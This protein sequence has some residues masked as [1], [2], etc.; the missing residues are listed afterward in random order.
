MKT[1]I[2]FYL[3]A[4]ITVT[5]LTLLPSSNRIDEEFYPILDFYKEIG[6]VIPTSSIIIKFGQLDLPTAGVCNKKIHLLTNDI[7]RRE[8]VISEKL[9]DHLDALEQYILVLH[10]LGHCIQDREH[11]EDLMEDRC[12]VS[13]MYPEILPP[14]CI[15]KH[16][17]YYIDELFHK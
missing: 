3:I 8:I 17:Y 13:L 4:A 14:T 6:G 7:V 1:R 2:A 9:W 5:L 11:I 10:E 12:P 16:W 15:E